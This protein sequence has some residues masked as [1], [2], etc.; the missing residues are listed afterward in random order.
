MTLQEKFTSYFQGVG[1]ISTK[2][3]FDWYTLVKS[4]DN[5]NTYRA[6][7]YALV[8][9]PLLMKGVLKKVEKGI[10][11]LNQT[12]ECKDLTEEEVS[13]QEQELDD[14]DRYIQEKIK[15]GM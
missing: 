2:E 4:G 7:I 10:Y 13:C 14:F 11:T 15:G 8:I 9:N 6:S 3:I 1:Y 5:P 12:A